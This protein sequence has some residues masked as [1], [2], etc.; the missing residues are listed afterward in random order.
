[1][2]SGLTVVAGL[3]LAVA[4]VVGIPSTAF[5]EDPV[6]FGASHVLDKVGALG[7]RESEVTAA[8]DTLYSDTRTDLY[9][10]FVDSFTGAADREQWAAETADR[11]GMGTND[12]LLAVATDDREYQLSA[13]N[14]FALTDAQLS[15]VQL[16]AIEPALRQNDWAGAAIGAA[17]GLEASLTGKQVTAPDIT[18]G[19]ANPQSS[20]G[21]GLNFFWIF[22]VGVVILGA[23]LFFRGRRRR[24]AVAPGTP[25]APPVP[26]GP[27]AVPTAELKQRAGSA[28]VQ[29]DD[30]VRTSEQELQFAIAQYGAEATTQFRAALD[31]AEGQLKQ[32]FGLQQKLDDAVPDTEEQIRAWYGEIIDLCAAA[33]AALDEQADAFTEL[34]QLEKNAPQELAAATGEAD[35]VER[36]IGEAET[37]RAALATGYSDDAIATVA[38]NDDQA[39]ARLEFARTAL[40]HAGERLAAGETAA[41]AVAIR[42]GQES[43]DQA[44]LLIDAIDRLGADLQE[45][46]RSVTATIADLETDLI[47]ARGLPAGDASGVN[48]PGVIA[49][50]EQVLADARSQLSGG[51]TNPLDL[52]R[53]LDAANT[54]MD[55]VLSGARDAQVQAQ[56]ARGAL[57]NVM[58]SAHSRISAA[59]DFI[60]ARRGA[61]GPDARTRLTE[62]GRLLSQ[63]DAQAATDPALALATAQR[64]DSL[65]AEAISLAQSDVD[66][67]MGGDPFGD[68]FRGGGR[69]RSG[70]MMGGGGGGT[71]GAV[72]GGIIISSVLNGGGGGGGGMFGGGGGGGGMFGGGGGGSFGGSG[73]FGGS[74]HRGGGGRF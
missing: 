57:S 2:R 54:Q 21:G 18:P 19:K 7:S 73:G 56:R 3:L 71:L 8:L 49:A 64:A 13:P 40:S 12:V 41:A 11:N 31:A 28:L 34:R 36:R 74:G 65:A 37:R 10:A 32:A 15:E 30:A 58:L 46:A 50:T 14:D 23:F 59:Q 68:V 29:T 69:P 51:R 72:L 22:I 33:N 4:T 43:V 38:D 20:G 35:A 26:A 55:A 63:A 24:T 48:V 45:A 61:I 16:T 52:A 1:M 25:G 42:A 53:R 66:G 27:P 5:A 44:K 39:R 60:T 62:A 9:V 67:Y 70:G 17:R 6:D 47:R